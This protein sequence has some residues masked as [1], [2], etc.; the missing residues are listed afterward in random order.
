MRIIS[1]ILALAMLLLSV[2]QVLAGPMLADQIASMVADKL[3]EK[4]G[5]LGKRP[6]NCQLVMNPPPMFGRADAN[7]APANAK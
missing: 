5:D 4:L 2:N 1:Q 7:N 6:C 3:K